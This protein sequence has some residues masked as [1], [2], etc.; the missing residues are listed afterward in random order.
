MGQRRSRACGTEAVAPSS[1]WSSC[2]VARSAWL[3]RAAGPAWRR[4]EPG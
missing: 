4:G 1:G 2:A 3:G